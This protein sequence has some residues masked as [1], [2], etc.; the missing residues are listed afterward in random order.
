[1][2]FNPID[3]PQD[4]VILAGQ[5]SPGIAELQGWTSPR[6]WDER[7]GYALSGA[8]LVYRGNALAA[9]KLILRLYT[10]EHFTGWESFREIVQRAPSGER[11]RSMEI[12]HPILEDLGV[13]SVV[14]ED[15][16]QPEKGR[17]GEWIV[18]ISLKE[19]RRTEVALAR[20]DGSE[21]LPQ[22]QTQSQRV[23]AALA[24]TLSSVNQGGEGGLA[25]IADALGEL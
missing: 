15:V 16:K 9:G 21:E 20:P 14:V 18:E 5:R 1:M 22:P 24:G 23:I 12:S 6:R 10:V 7:R 8:T 2:S 19:W 4:F 17:A 13:R 3:S 25:E 11:P